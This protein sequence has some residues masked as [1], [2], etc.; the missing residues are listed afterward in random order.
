M[1]LFSYDVA[2]I[3]KVL[4]SHGSAVEFIHKECKASIFFNLIIKKAKIDREQ[5]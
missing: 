2:D 3:F 4:N 5:L 1:I